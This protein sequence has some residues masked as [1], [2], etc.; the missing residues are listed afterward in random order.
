[1]LSQE[2]YLYT[3]VWRAQFSVPPDRPR[4]NLTVFENNSF[5]IKTK[6]AGPN[7]PFSVTEALTFSE[8][9]LRDCLHSVPRSVQ[10]STQPALSSRA[11]HVSPPFWGSWMMCL[12]RTRY[13]VLQGS[14]QPLQALHWDTTQGITGAVRNKECRTLQKW[15]FLFSQLCW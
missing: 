8:D 2:G 12:L 1:M 9:L 7:K 5:Q 11:G 15:V 6:S 10:Y 3:S 13:V 4:A 14:A